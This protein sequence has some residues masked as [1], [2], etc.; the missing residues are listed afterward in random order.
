[1]YDDKAT[2]VVKAQ[3]NV[4]QNWRSGKLVWTSGTWYFMVYI[5]PLCQPGKNFLIKFMKADYLAV[6][7]VFSTMTGI[8]NRHSVEIYWMN[9]SIWKKN[10]VARIKLKQD[11]SC[12]M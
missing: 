7:S 5:E 3:R 12:A 11:D 9:S 6:S 4:T 10:K 8:D 2:N 1:M